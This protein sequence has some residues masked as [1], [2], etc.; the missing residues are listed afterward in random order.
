MKKY[1]YASDSVNL[2]GKILFLF[3]TAIL[4]TGSFCNKA[5]C[6]EWSL[7]LAVVAKVNGQPITKYDIEELAGMLAQ[8]FVMINGEEALTMEEKEKIA[9]NALQ[10]LVRSKLIRQ[11]SVKNNIAVSDDDILDE[12][13]GKNLPDNNL[14]RM[15]AKDDLLFDKLM[16]TIGKPVL[17]A[18]PREVRDFYNENKHLFIIPRKVK[19]RHITV[20]KAT[21]MTRA[22]EMRKIERYHKEAQSGYMKFAELASKRASAP[23]DQ[24]TG[25]LILPPG[26]QKTGGFF[27]PESK[28][29][30]TTF[31]KEMV[32]AVQKLKKGETSEIIE[33]SIGFHIIYI[34][35]EVPAKNITFDQSQRYII[36]HLLD[37][38]RFMLQREWLESVIKESRITWHDGTTIPP[39]EVMPPKPKFD[40]S[41]AEGN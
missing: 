7:T 32:E 10:V 9:R 13:E 1:I 11:A 24:Q 36:R 39:E 2:S 31:P 33:S 28:A 12:L 23:I 16:R 8:R 4:L 35:D 30:T 3:I 37:V 27:R 21:E 26:S 40:A 25:G 41:K 17:E 19:A 6:G 20:T 38:E 15:F 29:F 18:S 5:I 34:D 22:S 14:N